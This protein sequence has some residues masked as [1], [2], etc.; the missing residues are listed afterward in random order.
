MRIRAAGVILSVFLTISCAYAY[1]LRPGW[2]EYKSDH[3]IIHH[4][5]DIPNKYI[6]EFTRRCERYYRLV[7]ERLGLMRFDFWSWENRARIFIYESRE[8]YTRDNGRPDWSLASVHTDKKFI[9]TF[10]F[11][12]GFF[13]IILPHELTHIILRELIGSGTKV[14]LWFEEGVACANEDNC[15]VKYLLLVKGFVYEGTYVSIAELEKAGRLRAEEQKTFY[16]I[17]ASVVIFLLE[18]YGERDFVQLCRELRD[19]KGFYGAMDRVYEIQNAAGLNEKFL[20]FLQ[21]K[22]YEDISAQGSSSMHW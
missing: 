9:N 3:F 5:P 19:G 21:N 22:T 14:P 6:R 18:E 2:N 13:N 12:E 16:P 10:Y 8:A 4:H 20:T 7:T 17:A 1:T 15:Y 11:E